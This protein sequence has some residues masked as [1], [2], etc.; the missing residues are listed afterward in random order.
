LIIDYS[1][2]ES[3]RLSVSSITLQ[4]TASWEALAD[5][6]QLRPLER[7]RVAK[8]ESQGG[9][10]G[11]KPMNLWEDLGIPRKTSEIYGKI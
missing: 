5:A 6:L 8:A 7:H 11:E 9:R 2:C 1:L 4:V 3:N 10:W